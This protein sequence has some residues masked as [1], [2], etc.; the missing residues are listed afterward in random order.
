MH[1]GTSFSG[2]REHGRII[3]WCLLAELRIHKL[4]QL[5]EIAAHELLEALS[6]PPLGRGQRC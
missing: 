2:L 5:L 4:R 3:H 6:D 1:S